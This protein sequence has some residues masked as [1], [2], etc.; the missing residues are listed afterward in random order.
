MDLVAGGAGAPVVVLG[1]EGGPQ[2]F[3]HG[4][5]LHAPARPIDT[6][7][8]TAHMLAASF[9][10]VNCVSRSAC[11]TTPAGKVARVAAA[12]SSAV[13]IR[14]RVVLL[15]HGV[16][17]DSTRVRI[18]HGAQVD[19]ALRAPQVGDIRDPHPIQGALI[20]LAPAVILMGHRA[21]PA[22]PGRARVRV[23]A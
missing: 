17:Q 20:P 3:G 14:A 15:A 23:Q 4:V 19:P 11:N 13:M 10:E 6:L 5:I 7:P 1:C 18:W 8:W 22:A 16:S 9:W 12:M 21:P 2:G